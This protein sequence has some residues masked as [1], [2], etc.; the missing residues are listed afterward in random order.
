MKLFKPIEIFFRN[1]RDSF[2][3]S[4]KDIYRQISHRKLD[5]DL[6]LELVLYGIPNTNIK[7]PK[8]LTADETLATIIATDKSLVRFGDGEIMLLEGNGVPF[9][10]EDKKL[11]MRLRQILANPHPNVLIGINRWYYYSNLAELIKQANP[12]HKNFNLYTMPKIRKAFEKYINYDITYCEASMSG[13]G[14][15]VVKFGEIFSKIK[16]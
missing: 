2:R 8:I 7:R 12:I 16:G 6:L 10:K 3:F 13:G 4:L 9:Q 1:M 5:D 15:A 11:T 14:G